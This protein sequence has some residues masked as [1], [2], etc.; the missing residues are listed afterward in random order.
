MTPEQ[1]RALALAR[2]RKRKAEAEGIP[3]PSMATGAPNFMNDGIDLVSPYASLSKEDRLRRN[4]ANR[5]LAFEESRAGDA[6][7]QTSGLEAFGIGGVN[8]L[9]LGNYAGVMASHEQAARER[10]KLPMYGN[11]L[12]EYAQD[13]IG[14][15]LKPGNESQ[16]QRE[17]YEDQ[18]QGRQGLAA[19]ENPA[20]YMGGE[21]AGY[22]APG[23]ALW[24]AGGRAA[25]ALPFAD[26][27]ARL[28]GGTRATSYAGR[29]A[30]AGAAFTGDAA[31]FGGTVGASDEAAISAA[32]GNPIELSPA[33]RLK[34]A[35][36]YATATVPIETPAGKL[37]VPV[38]FAA[39]VVGS[40][41][42]RTGNM[43]AKGYAT[44]DDIAA[45]VYETQGR[46]PFKGKAAASI[47]RAGQTL[48]GTVTPKNIRG[49]RGIENA[50]TDAL[51]G[52][53]V[54]GVSLSR[55][56][57]RNRIATGFDNIRQ[58]VPTLDEPGVDLARLIERE[59]SND[60]P[61]IQETIRR[62]LLK[63]GLD[64]PTGRTLLQNA[65]NE[66][67]GQQADTLTDEVTRQFGGQSKTEA[68]TVLKGNKKL[69]R[70][71][72]YSQALGS[73]DLDAPGQQE[74]L[75][76]LS[77]GSEYRTLLSEPARNAGMTVDDFV[78]K[79]PLR[80]LHEVR[81]RLLTRARDLREGGAPNYDLED[82]TAQMAGI[83]DANVPGYNQ[84]RNMF[85]SEA[86]AY[87]RMGT[88]RGAEG[89][90]G[91]ELRYSPGFGEKL[92]GGTPATPGITSRQEG[93]DV[94]RDVF[95][96]MDD[97]SKRTA[98]YSVRDVILSDL[99]R[100]RAAGV[101]DRYAV[102]AKFQRLQTEGALKALEE[103]FGQE[104]AA[105][106]RRVRQFVD[107]NQYARDIDPTYNSLTANKLESQKSGAVP[108]A[109]SIGR[110]AAGANNAL[111]ESAMVDAALILGGGVHAPI[112]SAMRAPGIITKMLQPSARTQQGIA[113]TL[114]RQPIQNPRPPRSPPPLPIAPL[115]PNDLPSASPPAGGSI[116]EQLPQYTANAFAR[117][118]SGSI[119]PSMAGTLMTVGGA[120]AGATNPIDFNKDGEFSAEERA[121]TAALY[122]G[123]AF[124][125]KKNMDLY[126][127]LAD[128]AAGQVT[129]T[130]IPTT[131][132][133]AKDAAVLL[134]GNRDL[135]DSARILGLKIS[136][137][138]LY[139]PNGKVVQAQVMRE[140]R[141]A[142][143][144]AKKILD[145]D[146][147]K[148]GK[149]ARFII[150]DGVS[151]IEWGAPPL[152]VVRPEKAET[153]Y[154]I[155]ADNGV[156]VS[157][158]QRSSAP[159]ADI[160]PFKPRE[161]GPGNGIHADFLANQMK[162][163]PP[164]F[165]GG[166][167]TQMRGALGVGDNPV[168]GNKPPKIRKDMPVGRP[169]K[170]GNPK[171][172]QGDMIRQQYEGTSPPRLPQGPMTEA[173][174]AERKMRE[175]VNPL[176]NEGL[177]S[178]AIRQRTGI[179]TM[180]YKGKAFILPESFA[181]TPSEDVQRAFYES[182]S[183]PFEQRPKW[184][185][186]IIRATGD[187]EETALKAQRQWDRNNPMMLD[188]P[189]P[190][191][192]GKGRV[193]KAAL[194][195]GLGAVGAGTAYYMSRPSGS[196]STEAL[197]RKR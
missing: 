34:V 164:G 122:G 135:M 113:E 140:K 28:A 106:G 144:A 197:P 155:A 36:Q 61:Q 35:R 40:A 132:A 141:R 100:A 134:N 1:Q 93:R 147:A 22:L 85:R 58:S 45:R 157:G 170:G 32:Q 38:N 52:V 180:V 110:N 91:G 66:I 107:A 181:G 68:K 19:T 24:K 44:P 195:G 84:L 151:S 70:E 59:F 126:G 188:T 133:E 139:G 142:L 23:S 16:Q 194:L 129:T 46:T 136:R 77:A 101:D 92:L 161:P 148:Q 55:D 192:S 120:G 12:L 76:V 82:L 95:A 73:L 190:Q 143:E 57:I 119:R 62:F 4:A 67:R 74:A 102:A 9:S 149:D 54:N 60:A 177:S 168:P 27:V 117:N 109:S 130:K 81:S 178:E 108:F 158:P 169:P 98:A 156:P 69:I 10:R 50:L 2:A 172:G 179:Q 41:L 47:A 183:L 97:K 150:D 131:Y 189:P 18:W 174:L 103:V 51:Q 128:R 48:N 14:D 118:E 5:R 37:P 3:A 53:E 79:N 104:G 114:L 153:Q 86:Q 71:K 56:Q 49:F 154:R 121:A 185:Q 123:A 65:T 138:D 162:P 166:P 196:T 8:A 146:L 145:D 43:L 94:A 64:S 99:D 191:A 20:P 33:D 186:E 15:L 80:A 6:D 112:M 17:A 111:S 184:V 30:G 165:T 42:Q 176:L 29:L 39:P 90:T 87:E 175:T 127:K 137:F 26:D 105:I 78:L 7:K 13:K 193:P 116:V 72:G 167:L 163:R 115:T 21:I 31:V 88:T 182:L 159:T 63:V 75:N 96:G 125:A 160:L 124:G 173:Q 83:L 171:I 152:E 187:S 11:P 89:G 25:R